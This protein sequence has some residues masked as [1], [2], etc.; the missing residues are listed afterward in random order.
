MWQGRRKVSPS[1]WQPPAG[2]E[3]LVEGPHSAPSSSVFGA[4]HAVL[5][6]T[7]SEGKKILTKIA[8]RCTLRNLVSLPSYENMRN[9]TTVYE[10][11]Y[12]SF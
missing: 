5:V 7:G 1:T 2:V 3:V 8:F 11:F 6:A 9:S 4:E 12:Q 10:L